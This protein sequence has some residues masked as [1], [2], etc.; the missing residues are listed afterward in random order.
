M[1]FLPCIFTSKF[2][3]S[4]KNFSLKI[5]SNLKTKDK[6]KNPPALHFMFQ[7][8]NKVIFDESIDNFLNGFKPPAFLHAIN[9]N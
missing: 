3:L 2:T 8:G 1:I 9:I 7:K 4:Y 6:I 5:L